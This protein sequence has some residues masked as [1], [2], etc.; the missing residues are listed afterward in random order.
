MITIVT[1]AAALS[2]AGVVRTA[3]LV[4]TDGFGRIPTRTH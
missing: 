4:S 3:R 1:V 2:V